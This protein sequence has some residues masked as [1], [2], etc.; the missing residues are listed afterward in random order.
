MHWLETPASRYRKVYVDPYEIKG[1]EKADLIL[2]THGLRPPL[3]EAC[4][5]RG[6]DDLRMP[7]STRTA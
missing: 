1:G 7:A 6:A 4:Q 5:V 2:I 3:P